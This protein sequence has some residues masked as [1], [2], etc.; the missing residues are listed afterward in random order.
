MLI[1]R[2]AIGV[3]P[4]ALLQGYETRI[5]YILPRL[6]DS[7]RRGRVR[8]RERCGGG[9]GGPPG[10]Q[11]GAGRGTGARRR[12][13]PPTPSRCG[14]GWWRVSSAS[15]FVAAAVVVASRDL[16]TCFGGGDRAGGRSARSRC[17]SPSRA[18]SSAPRRQ[19]ART[20]G[21]PGA[22]AAAT[23]ER[24]PRRVW[25]TLMTVMIAVSITVQSTG[26]N[27]NAIDSTDASFAVAG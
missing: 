7:R 26:S 24:A 19:C 13:P 14:R 5:E 2:Q 12:R 10:V 11:G 9:A 1:G 4:A 8:R 3:L 22:L 21:A 16:G 23:I 6:R 17:V 25:A 15:A 20:F 18:R 27:A